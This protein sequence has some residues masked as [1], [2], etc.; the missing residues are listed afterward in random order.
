VYVYYTITSRHSE[1]EDFSL[2]SL[3]SYQGLSLL[4]ILC[5]EAEGKVPSCA[6]AVCT[7][8]IPQQG[9]ENPGRAGKWQK[10]KKKMVVTDLS[11]R[12]FPSMSPVLWNIL[13]P[14][15]PQA[16]PSGVLRGLLETSLCVLMLCVEIHLTSVSALSKVSRWQLA[17]L[18]SS[19]MLMC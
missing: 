10:K 16:W 18:I 14:V 11:S 1:E 6:R 5:Q 15:P 4:V 12:A 9:L 7:P 17:N 19:F 2:R 3:L 8:A 13:F